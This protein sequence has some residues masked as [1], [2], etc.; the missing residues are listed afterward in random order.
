MISIR[1]VEQQQLWLQKPGFKIDLHSHTRFSSKPTNYLTKKL[2]IGEC[3]T[4]PEDAYK[5]AL[6]MGL[7]TYTCTDH[8][9]IDGN[10]YLRDKG[11]NV[12]ISVEV[13]ASFPHKNY[14]NR[15]KIH[16]LTYDLPSNRAQSIFEDI[17]G[18]RHNV[19][20]LIDYYDQHDILYMAAHPFYSVN[21]QLSVE[22]F[23]QMLLLF[24]HFEINGSKGEKTNKGL[25]YIIQHLDS[26]LL[27]KLADKH[28]RFISNPKISPHHKQC[29]KAGQD[30]HIQRYIGRSF[31]Y[32]PVAKSIRDLFEHCSS[33]NQ[34]VVRNSLPCNLNFVLY[35]V[36]ID[37]KVRNNRELEQ[38]LSLEPRL[39]A[40]FSMLTGKIPERPPLPVRTYFFL[41]SKLSK[42]TQTIPGLLQDE[43]L[44]LLCHSITRLPL[45]AF[46]VEHKNGN[47]LSKRFYHLLKQGVDQAVVSFIEKQMHTPIRTLLFNPCRTLGTIADLEKYILPYGISARIFHETRSFT[48]R[49]KNNL[50]PHGDPGTIR[51][52][53]FFDTFHEVNGPAK[54]AQGLAE[55]AAKSDIDYQII[56]C[57]SKESLYGEHHFPP[58]LSYASELYPDQKL[59]FPSF[60]DVINHCYL[61][62][63]THFHAATPGPLGLMAMVAAKHIFQ[64]P[65]FVT[66]H[67]DFARYLRNFTQ[68]SHIEEATWQFLK[69]FYNQSDIVFALSCDSKNSLIDHGIAEEKIRLLKRGIDMKR[70]VPPPAPAQTATYTITTS[71]RISMEKG[72]DNLTPAILKLLEKRPDVRWKFVGDGPYKP[73]LMRTF[74][75]TERVEFTGFLSGDDYVSAIQE[76]DL[77]VFPSNTDT[78]GQTPM[79][80]QACGVPVVVTNRGGPKDNVLDGENGIIVEGKSSLALLEGIEPLLDK[81][82]LQQ[83]GKKARAYISDRSFENAFKELCSHYH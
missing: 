50:Y 78:F 16:V 52:G 49:V 32:N 20:D 33:S 23:E 65:F 80:A 29:S 15:C 21:D 79:E 31:T 42:T 39:S 24:N 56:I 73:H 47:G 48:K 54:Y 26:A 12:P 17:D 14:R 75:T 74:A 81:S 37:Y 68:D 57:G 6:A 83:M 40:L 64:V 59:R 70:F 22:V 13:T 61:E 18:L 27:T 11:Y 36:G 38:L 25:D 2:G 55:L 43:P 7:S 51:V 69:F 72:L 8:D 30:A 10:L 9:T 3:V 66:H 46:N 1:T 35:C 34:V 41:K 53:H 63:Y 58:V 77:F 19:Y 62:D 45:A 44:T 67:T 4:D 28:S 71:C 5:T 60:M 82:L 76:S